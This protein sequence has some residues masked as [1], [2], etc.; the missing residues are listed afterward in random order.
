VIQVSRLFRFIRTDVIWVASG[1]LMALIV[2]LL[3]L[4]IFTN[5]FSAEQYAYIALMMALSAWIWTGVYQ[6]LNQTIFRF[7][8]L[9]M[10]H[11]W[12]DYFISLVL[13]YEKK[14][15]SAL[16][17]LLGI[18]L[19][20]AYVVDKER[21][22]LLLIILSVVMGISYG[23]V[24]GAVSF[25]LAQRKRKP[26]TV[27]Q[28]FDGL[29]R[30]VGG[31]TA[32]YCFSQ[33]EYATATGMALAGT[34]FFALVMHYVW[35]RVPFSK[36]TPH[37]LKTPS[38][39]QDFLSYFKKMF[40]VMFLNASII[41]LDKWLLFILIGD[42]AL[43]K[44]A[45]IYLLAMTVTTVVYFFFEMLGFPIIF[46]QASSERRK[47][48]LIA[49][50]IGYFLSLSLVTAISYNFGEMILLFFTTQYVATEYEVFTL[51]IMACGL[52]N[53]GR[54]LMVQGQ[55]DKEPHVYWPAYLV[56]LCF[57]VTWCLLFVGQDQGGGL[58]AAQGFVIGTVIFVGI[59]ALLN[60]KKIKVWKGM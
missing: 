45:I 46:N 37:Q 47:R 5:L 56:L 14:I 32:Y 48:Y 10:K 15:V 12:Q 54:I 19:L 17:V 4:K 53:F 18:S 49:L 21:S 36:V 44:Y 3:S 23:C 40:V 38:H 59:T 35:R 60:L 24:H 55:V 34:V 28:S 43:G 27:L 51:L 39:E 31:L 9:A 58:M 25:F 33:T 6:P 20:I 16:V 2:G 52:L 50:L 7:Y 26:V 13:E 11:D 30:L 22:F 41:H 1:Q 42:D 57:F 8:P 29:F